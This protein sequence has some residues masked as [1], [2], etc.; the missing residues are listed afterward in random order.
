MAAVSRPGVTNSLAIE[1]V[2]VLY[3]GNRVGSS[4]YYVGTVRYAFGANPMNRSAVMPRS[5]FLALMGCCARDFIE[6]PLNYVMGASDLS[7]SIVSTS[8]IAALTDTFKAVLMSSGLNTVGQILTF[9]V[10]DLAS[11]LTTDEATAL[12]LQNEIRQRFGLPTVA[13][14][15]AP[16]AP[17]TPQPKKTKAQ[18]SQ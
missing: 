13:A 3:V 17:A 5:D 11:L 9:S 15:V 10:T 16:V 1:A 4:N 6:I 18:A 8:T 2:G 14:P 7:Q 12:D